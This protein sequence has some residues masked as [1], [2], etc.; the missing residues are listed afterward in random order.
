[1]ELGWPTLAVAEE[2]GGLGWGLPEVIILM[3]AL[4]QRL[5]LIGGALDDRARHLALG[6]L[7]RVPLLRGLT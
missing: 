4:G 7:H 2:A 6:L 1:M 5:C 3:E